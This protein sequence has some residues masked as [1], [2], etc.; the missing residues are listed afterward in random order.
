MKIF[1]II[2]HFF[3]LISNSN[4]K[5][6]SSSFHTLFTFI[7]NDPCILESVFQIKIPNYVKPYCNSLTEMN[8][9]QTMQNLDYSAFIHIERMV[10]EGCSFSHDTCSQYCYIYDKNSCDFYDRIKYYLQPEQKIK[11]IGEVLVKDN[12]L[13]ALEAITHFINSE[14]HA[15]IILDKRFNYYG[16]AHYDNIFSMNFLESDSIKKKEKNLE[17]ISIL[18]EEKEY[19]LTTQELC[20]SSK[21]LVYENLDMRIYF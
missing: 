13:E 6:V 15:K 16:I 7:H 11:N 3:I 8:Y 2:I 1:F 5:I 20:D 21:I 17:T 18:H 14:P 4:S 12:S 10:D 19:I 9:I